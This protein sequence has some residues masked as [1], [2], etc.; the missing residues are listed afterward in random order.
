MYTIICIFRV[1]QR[2]LEEFI[3]VTSKSGEVLMS[4]GAVDHNILYSKELTGKQGSM[5]ILNLV[6]MEEDEE[7][8]LGQSVF[9]DEA[10]YYKVMKSV[11]S[12]DIIHYLD[13]NI[14]ELVEMNRV[15]TSRFTT[16]RTP[17][18]N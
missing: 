8:L 13:G 5:G 12:D 11:G 9:N 6:E 15:I 16:E 3:K 14:K 10:H 18:P 4:H 17:Q 7:L 2:N 1:N